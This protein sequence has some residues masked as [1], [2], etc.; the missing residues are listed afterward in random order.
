M[1]PRPFISRCLEIGSRSFRPSPR[2]ERYLALLCGLVIIAVTCR[3]WLALQIITTDLGL[4]SGPSDP[5][6][7][8]FRATTAWLWQHDPYG[9]VLMAWALIGLVALGPFASASWRSRSWPTVVWGISTLAFCFA[10]V[11]IG[12]NLMLLPLGRFG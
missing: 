5:Y 11:V 8:R 3:V 4:W 6:L 12:F 2:V 7:L 10:Y 1:P 9:I